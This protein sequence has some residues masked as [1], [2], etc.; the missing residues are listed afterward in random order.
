MSPIRK[1][2]V[3]SI[4]NSNGVNKPLTLKNWFRLLFFP[5]ILFLGII[6]GILLGGPAL[7]GYLKES[8]RKAVD[9]N[10]AIVKAVIYRKNAH[11]GRS[12]YFKY[13]YKGVQYNGSEDGTDL[14]DD[15]N[16]GDN[17]VIKID[18]LN[19]EN[20]YIIRY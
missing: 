7:S 2:K 15:L 12:V 10:G 16:S 8:D 5:F 11:K 20:A 4:K 1:I 19:P 6:A 9:K 17:I 14:Y 13:F 18:T 3:K